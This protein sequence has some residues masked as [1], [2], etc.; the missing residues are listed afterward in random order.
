MS[1][2]KNR[3]SNNSNITKSWSDVNKIFHTEN[4]LQRQQREAAEIVKRAERLKEQAR[5][6]LTE[7]SG[8]TQGVRNPR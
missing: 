8:G 3:K 6:V 4:P 2:R 5:E 1:Q 7:S